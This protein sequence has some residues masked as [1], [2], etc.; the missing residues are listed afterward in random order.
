MT[1]PPEIHPPNW[2]S[3]YAELMNLKD[4]EVTQF[5]LFAAY[6]LARANTVAHFDPGIEFSNAGLFVREAMMR[7]EY[8][9]KKSPGSE[10]PEDDEGVAL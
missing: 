5:G 1:Q 2:V 3:Q 6:I 9:I 8:P 4:E 10:E 7:F